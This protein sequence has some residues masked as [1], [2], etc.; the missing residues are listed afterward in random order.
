MTISSF[1]SSTLKSTLARESQRDSQHYRIA[2][3]SASISSHNFAKCLPPNGLLLTQ[4][5]TLIT[6]RN[7]VCSF[8]FIFLDASVYLWSLK[9]IQIIWRTFLLTTAWSTAVHPRIQWAP[10]VWGPVQFSHF[11]SFSC[12]K[13][14]TLL[15][16]F[17]DIA[18]PSIG[19]QNK[20]NSRWC[21]FPTDTEDR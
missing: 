13:S 15:Y 7:K 2:V 12:R 20:K 16:T 14:L 9:N 19:L 8:S 6:A 11:I 5:T 17:N 10:P 18:L 1:N 21:H 3:S 4:L